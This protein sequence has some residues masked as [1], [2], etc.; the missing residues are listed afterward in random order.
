[1]EILALGKGHLLKRAP[2]HRNHSKVLE[3]LENN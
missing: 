3:D 2:L 1:M